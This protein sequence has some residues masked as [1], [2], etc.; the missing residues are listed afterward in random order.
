[1]A[2]IKNLKVG[3]TIYKT[4]KEKMGNTTISTTRVSQVTIKSI[5][6][7]EGRIKYNLHGE[8]RSMSEFRIKQYRVSK[9]ILIEGFTGSYRVA[10]KEEIKKM[11]EEKD[12]EDGNKV[13]KRVL[14]NTPMKDD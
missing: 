14:D 8:E 6:L 3:Q 9:P 7:I 4:Y 11:K 12:I 13:L 2:T 5:D 10:T 1:M